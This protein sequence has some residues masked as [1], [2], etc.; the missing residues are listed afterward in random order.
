MSEQVQIVST[1]A[2]ASAT[3]KSNTG[4][5]KSTVSK[6]S[7]VA[8]PTHPRTSDMVNA[9]IS[10]LKERGGSSIHAI[11]KYITSTYKLDSEKHALFIRKY[12]K[13]AVD[14]GALIQTRG[15][16]A[17]GSFKLSSVKLETKKPE[18]KIIPKKVPA[19]KKVTVAKKS[20]ARKP[21]PAKKNDT[22]KKVIAKKT[23]RKPVSRKTVIASV[24]PKKGKKISEVKNRKAKS[25]PKAKKSNKA[26]VVMPKV[27]KPKRVASA[28]KN[29]RAVAKK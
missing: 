23:L 7:A 16:G 1:V 13:A 4:K 21:V 6:S 18:G 9:A 5:A 3:S 29:V 24:T 12:L 15:K 22:Q 19:P 25:S 17:S 2:M 27:P 10:D 20:A 11:K 8:K 26:S 28:S 14:S